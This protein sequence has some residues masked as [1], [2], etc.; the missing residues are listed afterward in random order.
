[1]NEEQLKFVTTHSK[2]IKEVPDVSRFD[3]RLLPVRWAHFP[4]YEVAYNDLRVKL[5][6]NPHLKGMRILIDCNGELILRINPNATWKEISTMMVAASTWYRSQREQI[7]KNYDTVAWQAQKECTYSEGDV[8]DAGTGAA[9]DLTLYGSL[10]C[11]C[12]L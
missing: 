8:G 12:R 11:P 1:M 9:R 10:T 4:L 2:L 5:Q 7:Y 3:E 6:T